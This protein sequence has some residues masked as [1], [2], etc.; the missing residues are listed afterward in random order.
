MTEQT[1]DNGLIDTSPASR[2]HGGR[3]RAAARQYQIPVSDWLDLSTGINPRGWPVPP[4]LGDWWRL[5]E[6]DDGLISAALDYYGADAGHDERCLL[7]VAGSQAAIGALPRLRPPAVVGIIAP[8]YAEH[9]RAWRCAGHQVLPL[10]G[11][12]IDAA[13]P[14]LDVLVLIHPNNPTGRRFSRRQL[15][16]WL[17]ALAARGGWLVID[18]AFIDPTPQESLTGL[19]PQQGLILLRSIG[20][21]FGLAGARVGFVLAWPALIDALAGWLGPWCVANPS[22]QVAAAALADRDW[23]AAAR[24]RLIAAGDRLAELMRRAELPPAGGTALFQWAPTPRAAE[25]YERLART[26]ILARCFDDPPALRL[27]LPGDEAGWDRLT[28]TLRELGLG[29]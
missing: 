16:D 22:R 24:P 13:L 12:A 5:P 28:Q 20:K 26:G 21:F 10:A 25:L 11:D 19:G 17:G 18:E 3:L 8:S 2:P 27:G 6:D 7:P 9:A 14:G 1:S 15:Q 23:Q 4:D 29:G